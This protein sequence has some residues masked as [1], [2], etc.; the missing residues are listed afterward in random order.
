MH[1]RGRLYRLLR[2]RRARL[3]QRSCNGTLLVRD[4]VQLVSAHAYN[5]CCS[6][7]A[8]A[9]WLSCAYKPEAVRSGM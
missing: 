4:A 2:R 3:Q 7:P 6:F 5:N 9:C 8:D 1:G